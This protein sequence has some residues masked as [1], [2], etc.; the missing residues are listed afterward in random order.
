MELVVLII[1]ALVCL[2]FVL[3]LSFHNI[4]GIITNAA[5]SAIFIGLSWGLA[6]EQSKTQIADWLSQ[7]ELML[8]TS[9]LLTIDVFLQLV[10]CMLFGKKLIEEKLQRTETVSLVVTQ[11]IPGILIF[12]VLFSTLVELI[13]SFPGVDFAKI[14]WIFGSVALVAIPLL[15]YGMRILFPARGMRLELIFLINGLIAVLGV[16]ATVNGRTAVNGTTEIE[17]IALSGIC[18]IMAIG[19]IIGFYLSKFINKKRITKILKTK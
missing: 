3:K 12:P 11:W 7:P 17:W 9:V 13:F 18:A 15:T 8:D 4:A 16:I 6:V 2:S 19:A 14:A 1:M 10:F 5:M